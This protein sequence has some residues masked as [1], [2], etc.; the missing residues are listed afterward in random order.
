MA[1]INKADTKFLLIPFFYLLL[2]IWTMILVFLVVYLQVEPPISLSYILLYAAV[3]ELR[4]LP[5]PYTTLK[6]IYIFVCMC[7]YRVLVIQRK[8]S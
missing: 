6:I 8:V 2:R 7:K 1:T 4:K 3:S 5:L